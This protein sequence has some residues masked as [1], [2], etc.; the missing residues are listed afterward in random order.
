MGNALVFVCPHCGLKNEMPVIQ[1]QVQAFNI[2]RSEDDAYI[3]GR[4]RQR[5]CYNC[6][7]QILTAE[8]HEDALDYLVARD[9]LAANLTRRIQTA[10]G[11]IPSDD[12]LRVEAIGCLRVVCSVFGERS[13]P[14]W[15]ATYPLSE[16]EC[17]LIIFRMREALALLGAESAA[18]VKHHFGVLLDDRARLTP[19][20]QDTLQKSIR[21]LKHPS[22]SRR[23][24]SLTTFI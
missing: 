12:P 5:H 14:S 9:K 2:M 8:I 17:A 15:E 4:T 19:V 24:K 23:L 1:T 11:S 10:P 3:S 20:D 16:S 22:R 6:D 21:M 18:A 7:R 13:Q